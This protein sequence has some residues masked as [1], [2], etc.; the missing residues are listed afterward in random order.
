KKRSNAEP[1]FDESHTQKDQTYKDCKNRPRRLRGREH[2]GAA[3]EQHERRNRV[4]APQD[5]GDR[6]LVNLLLRPEEQKRQ[7][8]QMIDTCDMRVTRDADDSRYFADR[9]APSV[10]RIIEEPSE[11]HRIEDAGRD[12]CEFDDGEQSA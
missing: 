2:D 12:E 3:G 7:E 9:D 1:S 8:H 6:E 5:T 10:L 4:S 11:E